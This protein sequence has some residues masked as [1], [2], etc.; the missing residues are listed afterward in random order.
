MKKAVASI[1]VSSC[2]Q[3]LAF[4]GLFSLSGFFLSIK[5]SCTHQGASFFPYNK[6][7]AQTK[8]SINNIFLGKINTKTLLSTLATWYLEQISTN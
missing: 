1:P 7:V 3:W 2:A 5:I 4:V 8:L 6:S